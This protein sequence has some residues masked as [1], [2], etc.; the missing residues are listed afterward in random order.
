MVRFVQD[1]FANAVTRQNRNSDKHGRANVLIF[2]VEDIVLLYTETL[3]KH[4]VTNVGSS[5]LLPKYI[6]QFRVLHRKTMRI[7]PSCLAGWLLRPMSVV[8]SR[9]ISTRFLP[10]ANTTATFKNLQVIC[11]APSQLLNLAR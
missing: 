5:K 11:L 2:N 4:I 9:T 10:R 8:S 1:F 3:P 7:L 6:G